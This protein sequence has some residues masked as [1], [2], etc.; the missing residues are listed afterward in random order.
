MS[1]GEK[2]KKTSLQTPETSTDTIITFEGLDVL[3]DIDVF[4]EKLES[5]GY[6]RFQAP[7]ES[8]AMLEDSCRVYYGTFLGKEGT[9][10]VYANSNARKIE[11]I[12]TILKYDDLENAK[13][14]LNDILNF[15]KTK[16]PKAFY[17]EDKDS[18]GEKE[19]YFVTQP[20]LVCINMIHMQDGSY[21]IHVFVEETKY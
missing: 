7:T 2:V 3:S 15:Y 16:Y 1:C 9:I 10:N 6:E 13:S 20:V 4:F 14:N 11:Y 18:Y 5:K 17:H 12:R 19:Y 21:T 8:G